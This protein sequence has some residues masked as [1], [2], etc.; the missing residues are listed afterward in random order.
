MICKNCDYRE[1]KEIPD[2]NG[3]DLERRLR[4]QYTHGVDVCTLDNINIPCDD[5]Y[6]KCPYREITVEAQDIQHVINLLKEMGWDAEELAIE[7]LK[8]ILEEK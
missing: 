6:L 1:V 2:D 7:A 3:Y 4:Q 5:A 8:K